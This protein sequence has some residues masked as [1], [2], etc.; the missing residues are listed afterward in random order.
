MKRKE[1]ILSYF[2]KTRLAFIG[3][4]IIVG[5]FSGLIVSLF[6][7]LIEEL[8]GYVKLTYALLRINPQ[9]IF[10]WVFASIVL[11]IG[12]GLIIKKDPMIKGSGIPQIEGQ[13]LGV[14][15]MNWL[16]IILRKGIAGILSIGSGLFLGR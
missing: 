13:M 16:S 2:D 5:V 6:R 4:G 9:W 3:K 15:R 14:M 12:I 7:Y 8:L 11:A 10:L 1:E